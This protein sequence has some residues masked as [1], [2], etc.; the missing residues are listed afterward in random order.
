M[1]KLLLFFVLAFAFKL[2]TNAQWMKF[3]APQNQGT[4]VKVQCVTNNVIYTG[5]GYDN[6][7]YKSVD[8][9][10]TWAYTIGSLQSGYPNSFYF[11]S[12]DTGFVVCDKGY[13]Y[14]TTNGGQSFAL[15]TRPYQ[16]YKDVVF[17]NQNVGFIVGNGRVNVQ[18]ADTAFILKTIDG[19]NTWSY[20]N[21][22]HVSN[23]VSL[24]FSDAM[25]GCA[26]G[27]SG[28]VAVTN[29]G[30]NTWVTKAT[31]VTN[32]FN[33]VSMVS[34]NVIYAAGS[35]VFKQS[36]DGGNTWT[37]VSTGQSPSTYYNGM[38][39]IDSA[40][41]HIAFASGL[42]SKINSVWQPR[43]SS[44]NTTLRDVHFLN[45]NTGFATGNDGEIYKY[46]GNTPIISISNPTSGKVLF[47][48]AA[49][50]ITWSSNAIDTISI[51]YR[52]SPTANWQT[53]VAKQAA[54]T[55]SYS[56]NV[57]N[58]ETTTASFRITDVANNTHTS[59]TNDNITFTLER[60]VEL[61]APVKY[62]TTHVM[63]SKIVI[64]WNTINIDTL[65]LQYRLSK[66]AAWLLIADN[67]LA[68]TKSYLFTIP[69]T[70]TS[71]FEVKV[72]AK[73]Y[74][75]YADSTGIG[76]I[77]EKAIN[78]AH[79]IWSL[80]NPKPFL[81]SLTDAQIISGDTLYALANPNLLVTSSNKG[82]TW[83]ILSEL[84]LD[85]EILKSFQ[86][87]NSQLGY[88]IVGNENISRVLKTTNAGTSWTVV[89][90]SL[91]GLI[92]G[93]Q[94]LSTT[95]IGWVYGGSYQSSSIYYTANGGISF[96]QQTVNV[97]KTIKDLFVIN[98]TTAWLVSEDGSLCNTTNSGSTW[99]TKTQITY[100]LN[101]LHF[102][103]S[104][105][106]AAGGDYS[107]GRILK[108][109]DN[110]AT[111]TT[112]SITGGGIDG[113]AMKDAN[114]GYAISG[115]GSSSTF[116]KKT[117][118]GW[119]TS[120]N[121]NVYNSNNGFMP[122]ANTI[123]ILPN[124]VGIAFKKESYNTNPAFSFVI[125]GV[126]VTSWKN[127]S[128]EVLKDNGIT[129]Y[130]STGGIS[131]IDS[132]TGYAFGS[133]L[134][135]TT[136]GGTDWNIASKT[137]YFSSTSHMQF[138]GK[139]TGFLCGTKNNISGIY[140]TTNGGTSWSMVKGTGN[141]APF[142]IH[143]TDKLNGF[144]LA[145]SSDSIYK[146]TDGGLT[147]SGLSRPSSTN[148]GIYFIDANNGFVF[149]TSL[150][151]TS[152][153][154]ASWSLI[155]LNMNGGAYLTRIRFLDN[156][157]GFA[158]GYYGTLPDGG[159][160]AYIF[161]TTDGGTTWNRQI[162]PTFGGNT[163]R[164]VYFI[165]ANNGFASGEGAL[166][167]TADGGVNW[168]ITALPIPN[169]TNNYGISSLAFTDGR[170]GWAVASNNII[171]KCNFSAPIITPPTPA[172]TLLMPNGGENYPV[173]STQNITWS[174]SNIDSLKIEYRTSASS[175]WIN[176]AKVASAVGSYSWAIPNTLTNDAKVRVSSTIDMAV[177]D[178][179]DA[180]FSIIA[181]TTPSI[182]LVTPN[183]GE[184]WQ[185]TSTQNI[186]WVSALIDTV[187]IEYTIGGAYMPVA[188]VAAASGTYTWTIPNTP[189]VTC[190]VK[191]TDAANTLSD[192]SNANFE[193]RLTSGLNNLANEMG[194]QIYPNPFQDNFNINLNLNENAEVMVTVF[195]IAGKQLQQDNNTLNA[196]LQTITIN[197]N[198]KPGMYFVRITV[199]QK[200]ATYRLL[201]Q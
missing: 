18:P 19:G 149:G 196:G 54:N 64:G 168:Y 115:Y 48:N 100:P 126:D 108:T 112:I 106:W 92:T 31:G 53:I 154:G 124:D 152:N 80:Q 41:A 184:I 96:T 188:R 162:C 58:I 90:E 75:N 200:T 86:F 35:S 99:S 194:L 29:D 182:N 144:A 59:K 174:A 167:Q 93:I 78:T 7:L 145:G 187:V 155:S 39:F 158:V 38:Y 30:G 85:G 102:I 15:I 21:L 77:R 120:T 97:N 94:F 40:N 109:I 67:V 151:K 101:D 146:T 47:N 140:R 195:D 14:K 178:T 197:N 173:A 131:M 127:I 32:S 104:T 130:G 181:A 163:L 20:Y 55:N 1:K 129:L 37:D 72:T 134:L 79:P 177:N 186:T 128:N 13:I 33:D 60:N 68:S 103:G 10:Y 45:A 113:I 56:W 24:S 43:V 139:D 73:N 137:D 17:V 71:N 169:G 23:M 201:K 171:M 98:S 5:G 132:T 172:V 88:I 16:H 44:I 49:F 143:L 69:N 65:K 36:V 114:T 28:K 147:W 89:N 34:A 166:F 190:K 189:T 175:A 161:K 119:A 83:T 179:S 138:I 76:T 6:R 61:T 123:L 87:F 63:A 42:V 8:G 133:Y 135:K 62:G 185:T 153:A 148:Q 66:N 91:P 70:T 199:N 121:M 117:T 46:V 164:D 170:N 3:S 198:L 159:L 156:N 25:H 51:E 165:D 110:G 82:V 57:P 176:I 180:T 136:N 118:D 183:G 50:N 9:G 11:L 116:F 52:V 191:I 150:Y 107:N 26:V 111:W 27:A 22:G 95:D 2:S 141:T 12:P 160:C 192:S 142:R 4:F 74:S 84:P 157:I 125:S 81:G 105:G 122:F 193:I